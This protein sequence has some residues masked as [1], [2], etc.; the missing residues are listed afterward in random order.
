MPAP[1]LGEDHGTGTAAAL[2]LE[3]PTTM[4]YDLT[5]SV[6]VSTS[7]IAALSAMYLMSKDPERR[8]RAWRLL[9]LLLRR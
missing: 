9:K 2:L 6:A 7:G 1:N 4:M 3:G 8:R 5:L